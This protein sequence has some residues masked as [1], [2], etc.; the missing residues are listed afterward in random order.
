MKNTIEIQR[1]ADMGWVIALLC[2]G[3]IQKTYPLVDFPE[4]KPGIELRDWLNHNDNEQ[5]LIC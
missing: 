1:N 4:D 5:K 3:V 2:N